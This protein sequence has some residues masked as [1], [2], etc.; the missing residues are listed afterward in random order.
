M[1][2]ACIYSLFRRMC[3]AN[4]QRTVVTV[5][6]TKI[7]TPEI[8]QPFRTTETYP[9]NHVTHHLNRI[10]TVPLDI[11]NLLQN[12][13]PNEWKKQIKTFA[14]FAILIRKPAVETMSYLEQADYTKSINKYILYGIHGVGKTTTLLHLIHYGFAKK[15]IMLHLPSVNTWFRFPKEITNSL[16]TPGKIDLPIHAGTWLKYFR[17]LNNALLSALDLKVSKDYTWSHRESTKSGESLSNL[18]E[19]GIQRIKFACGVVNAL[20]DELKAASTAGKC[21]ML[22]VIDGFNALTD[23]YTSIQDDNKVNVPAER[24]SLTTAFLNSVNYNW[25]NGAA[26]LTVDIRATKHKRESEYPRYLLGKKGFEHVDPF[27]PVCVE[28]YTSDEFN[29]IMEY[30]KDR[31]W[32]RNITANGQ[33]ELELLSNRNPLE[34]W[35]RCKPL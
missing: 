27:V 16:L 4:G 8:E 17:N 24:I 30:Y 9:P 20:V 5:A 10:Y 3:M 34:L 18:I 33:R 32:I 1:M 7:E 13:I 12:D 26:I 14:E 6:A 19:F 35:T 31:K 23:D 21:R 25:C 15:F 29:T 22:V 11:Q 2:S 28:N